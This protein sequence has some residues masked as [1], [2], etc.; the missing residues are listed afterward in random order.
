MRNKIYFTEIKSGV[1]ERNA[2]FNLKSN[3]TANTQY[4]EINVFGWRVCEK[5]SEV[6]DITVKQIWSKHVSF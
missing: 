4:K 3:F 6:I 1:F 5:I 2:W